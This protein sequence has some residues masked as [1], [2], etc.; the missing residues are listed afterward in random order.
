[1]SMNVIPVVLVSIPEGTSSDWVFD[2]LELTDEIYVEAE[3]EY[4]PNPKYRPDLDLNMSNRNAI[5]VAEAIG[6]TITDGEVENMTIEEFIGR[7][8][9]WLR[10]NF[11]KPSPEVPGDVSVGARGAVIH[12]A[13]VG[14]GYLS[15]KIRRCAVIAR[16]GLSRGATH[17]QFA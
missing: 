7:C 1:M 11:G 12:T 4:V 6:M 8:D 13:G 3:D 5:F 16:E 15:E 10:A 17:M 9:S 14:Q 2:S